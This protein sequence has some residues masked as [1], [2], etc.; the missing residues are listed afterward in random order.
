L[1][2]YRSGKKSSHTLQWATAVAKQTQ[3]DQHS[4]P[5]TCHIYTVSQKVQFLLDTKKIEL[6]RLLLAEALHTRD[7]SHDECV[8][9]VGVERECAG[10]VDLV[11]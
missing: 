6:T 4:S 10:V 8:A 5:Q 3:R 11:G 2:S 7:G 1:T 9:L